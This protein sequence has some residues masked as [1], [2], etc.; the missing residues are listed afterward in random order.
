MHTDSPQRPRAHPPVKI[1]YYPPRSQ[2]S[3]INL[4]VQ[5]VR[6]V[7]NIPIALYPIA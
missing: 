2:I 7:Q 5:Y 4:F 3:D 1:F 6:F